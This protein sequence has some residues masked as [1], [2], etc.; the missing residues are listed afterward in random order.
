MQSGVF[1]VAELVEHAVAREFVDGKGK[2][3]INCGKEPQH[4]V[5]QPDVG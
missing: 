4:L 1:P 5:F 3:E 2:E